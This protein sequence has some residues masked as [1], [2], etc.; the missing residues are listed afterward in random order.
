MA[1]EDRLAR[2]EDRIAIAELRHEY[3]YRADD[4]DWDGFAALFT[5]DAHLDFGPVGTFDG[6]ASVRRFAEEIVGSEHPF[7]VHMLHNPVIDVDGDTATGQWYVEVP[8]TFADGSAGWIQGRYDDTYRRVDG[9]WRFAE[10]LTEF[11]YLA[12]YHEGWADIVAET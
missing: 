3:C 5:E 11:N 12:D 2:I 7:L 10:V 6:R 1:L 4:R 8:C 9:E